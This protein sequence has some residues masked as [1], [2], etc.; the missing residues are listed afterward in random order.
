MNTVLKVLL[1]IVLAFLLIAGGL[2]HLGGPDGVDDRQHVDP[3]RA[4]RRGLVHIIDEQHGELPLALQ[5]AQI[6][7]SLASG[8]HV[9]PQF[10]RYWESPA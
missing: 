6:G 4:R 7:Y 9:A 5:R 10:A 8:F 2:A 1:G 3:R